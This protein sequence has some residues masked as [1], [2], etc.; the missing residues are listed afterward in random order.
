M[1][2]TKRLSSRPGQWAFGLLAVLAMGAANAQKA[3][4]AA[5]IDSSGNYQQEVKAC[6]SGQTAEDQATCLREARAARAEKK[7]GRLDT[8]G[9]LQ[10]NALARCDVF[11]NA[12]DKEACRGRVAGN[13]TV[14]G[15]V[16]GGG[17]LR[18]LEVTVPAAQTA[19]EPSGTQTLGGPQSPSAP[20]SAPPS[21]SSMPSDKSAPSSSST[22][23]PSS[24]SMPPASPAPYEPAPAP[25]TNR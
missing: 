12:D 1:I 9:D 4:D 24:S 22:P 16:A 2:A 19:S 5:S 23:A 20:Q 15:S 17:L 11:K 10:A 7:R 21:G 8:T 18:E 13:A 14:T 3:G 6:R 25:S